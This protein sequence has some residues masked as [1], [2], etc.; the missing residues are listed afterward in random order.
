VLTPPFAELADVVPLTRR[1]REVALLAAGGMT[2]KDIADRLYISVRSVD[3]HL[4][5]VYTKLGA[6]GRSELSTV[7]M[8][9]A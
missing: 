5:R 6:T 7:L 9:E 1:E 8:A 4:S 3:N 2:S